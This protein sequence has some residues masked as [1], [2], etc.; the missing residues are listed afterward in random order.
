MMLKVDLISSL[1]GRSEMWGE[2]MRSTWGRIFVEEKDRLNQLQNP[3]EIG[4][5]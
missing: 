5:E 1:D 3:E 2:V 4:K